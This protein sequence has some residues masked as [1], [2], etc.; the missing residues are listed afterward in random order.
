MSK[1]GTAPGPGTGAAQPRRRVV[2]SSLTGW[3]GFDAGRAA[4]EAPATLNLVSLVLFALGCVVVL[5]IGLTAATTPRIA[6][7]AFLIVAIFLL[8]NKVWSPQYSLW[9]VPLAVLAVPRIKLLVPWMAFDA[10]LWVAHMSYFHGVANRGIDPELFHL[11]VLTRNL[12]VVA[13]CVA[14]IVEIYRPELDL[15]RRS[16]W[17]SP[18][19]T[20]PLAGVLAD[21]GP[22]A[23][24]VADTNQKENPAR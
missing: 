16:H 5:A 18:D 17:N 10:L 15:V 11:L 4:G 6:Q 3:A 21:A 14:V 20:D 2:I 7:L 1:N 19:G 8:T 24:L 9:L 12:L 13:V 23:P 22:A